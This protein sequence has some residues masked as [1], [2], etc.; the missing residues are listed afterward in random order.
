MG[1]L[2][3]L[4]GDTPDRQAQMGLLFQ[5][6]SQ[7]NGV[8]GLLAANAYAQQAPERAMQK[9]FMD[10]KL[11]EMLAQGDERKANAEKQRAALEQAARLRAGMPSLFRQPGM[12]GGEAVPQEV[13]GVPM[14]SQPM[15]AAPMQSAPGGFDVQAALRLGMDPKMI[16]AYAGL[17]NV[18]RPEVARTLKGM[19]DGREVETQY[20]KYGQPIGDGLPQY[21]APISVNRGNSMDFLDP[22]NLKPQASLKTFQSPDSAASNAVTMRGQNMTDARARQTA[23]QGKW[24]YDAQRGGLV[25]MQSGEFKPAMQDGQ[26]VETKASREAAKEALQRQSTLAGADN[27]LKEVKDA[28]GLVGWNTA[29]VGGV[30]ANIPATD[31]RNLSA[32]LSTIK[33]NLGFDRLQQMRAESPTGGALG[34]VAVQE[35]VALQATVASLDQLQGS[36]QLGTALDKIETHYTNWKNAVAQSQGGKGGATGN[37][38]I[39][40]VN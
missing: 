7:R 5:G 18:G 10:A 26:P 40:R 36:A 3:T 1:L 38:G 2:D 37:W 34:A 23:E 15:G 14:F 28:K 25:N 11:A 29:G 19:K 13:G 27:V 21:R 35:L 16:E 31:A 30:L 4:L 24:Q 8:G 12:T 17:Q 39:K 6:L 22:F 9:Q 33:A 20:D 32:K